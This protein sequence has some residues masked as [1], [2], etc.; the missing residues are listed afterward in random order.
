M[1]VK[2]GVGGVWCKEVISY[3]QK[4]QSKTKETH[5]KGSPAS[6]SKD[7]VHPGHVQVSVDSGEVN[8]SKVET[9]EV[10][11]HEVLGSIEKR[12]VLDGSERLKFSGTE[13]GKVG[14]ATID[15]AKRASGGASRVSGLAYST[16]RS[17]VI[18]SQSRHGQSSA[19]CCNLRGGVPIPLW[20]ATYL[21][22]KVGNGVI[23]EL[24]AGAEVVDELVLAREAFVAVA[25]YA[26]VLRAVLC[27]DVAVQGSKPYEFGGAGA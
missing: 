23:S 15:D 2:I 9:T 22:A 6:V 7:V 17:G 8:A 14:D 27:C 1:R 24:V 13:H 3:E 16:A 20:L 4:K 12:V 10:E 5:G 25:V 11:V 26:V 18:A 21:V 19:S